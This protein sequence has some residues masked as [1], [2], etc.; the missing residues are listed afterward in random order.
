MVTISA[1]APRALGFDAEQALRL[2]RAIERNP[3]LLEQQSDVI[4]EVA[5]FP[6]AREVINRV[7]VTRKKVAFRYQQ[8]RVALN[9][10]IAA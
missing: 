6:E 7:F 10:A 9:L 8:A 2:A 3:S 5:A 4:D 1:T